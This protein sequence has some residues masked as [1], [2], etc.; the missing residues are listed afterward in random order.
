MICL[1]EMEVGRDKI[2]MC[3][4]ELAKGGVIWGY[5]VYVFLVPNVLLWDKIPPPKK[6]RKL[7]KA[8]TP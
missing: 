6:E 7:K 8:Q 4:C 1:Y 3:W 2:A 5:L